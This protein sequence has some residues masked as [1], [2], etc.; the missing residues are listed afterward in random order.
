MMREDGADRSS[1]SNSQDKIATIIM[2]VILSIMGAAIFTSIIVGSLGIRREAERNTCK[3]SDN[4]WRLPKTIIPKSY[5]IE[6][7]PSFDSLNFTGHSDIKLTIEDYTNC[8]FIHR[9]GISL[10]NVTLSYLNDDGTVDEDSS[11]DAHEIEYLDDYELARISFSHYLNKGKTAMLSMDFQGTIRTDLEGFYK[12][13]FDYQGEEHTLAVTHFEAVAARRA[14]PCF[15]EPELKAEFSFS[16]VLNRDDAKNMKHIANM[17]VVEENPVDGDGDQ[18]RVKYQTSV[19]MSTYL[20]A[21]MIGEMEYIEATQD[22]TTFRVWAVKGR[23]VQERGQFALQ[24][25]Q[26][27]TSFYAKFYD[28]PYALPKMDLLAVPDFDAGAMENWGMITFRETALLVDPNAAQSERSYV[29]EV[30]AHEIAH[31][32]SGNLVTMAWWN[33]LWLNEGFA[34]FFEVYSTDSIFPE[35]NLWEK[36]LTDAYRGALTFDASPASHPVVVADELNTPSELNS[37][38]DDISYDKGSMM[39]RMIYDILGQDGFQQWLRKYFSDHKYMAAYT[40]DIMATLAETSDGE[41][42][43][44]ILHSWFHQP[45][46]PVVMLHIDP[47]DSSK[48]TLTQRRFLWIQDDHNKQNTSSTTTNSINSIDTNADESSD[49]SAIKS[50]VW[51]L[52]VSMRHKDGSI[53]RHVFNQ[54]EATISL[55][56]NSDQYLKL[57][58]E[59]MSMYRVAYPESV[60]KQLSA[61]FSQLSTADR[62]GLIDDAFALGMAQRSALGTSNYSIH[63]AMDL[64]AEKLP[65]ER[66]Y[67]VWYAALSHLSRI[68]YDIDQLPIYGMFKHFMGQHILEDPLN[69]VG[70]EYN[71]N[72]DDSNT[73]ALRTLLIDSALRY[74]LES[75]VETA[76]DKYEAF[77]ADPISNPIERDIRGAIYK[78]YVRENGEEGWN[79]MLQR[80][81]NTSAADVPERLRVLHALAHTRVPYLIQE[82]LELAVS[83]H[84]RS[85]DA[86]YFIR[87]IARNVYGRDITWNFIRERYSEMRDRYGDGFASRR[88]AQITTLFSSQTMH[89]EVKGYFLRKQGGKLSKNLNE[90]LTEILINKAFLDDHYDELETW[91]SDMTPVSI[92][93]V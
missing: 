27:V 68:A 16:F 76:L 85:Q 55:N 87:E 80:Y 57:N 51:Y 75:A 70:W 5:S 60:W 37:V 9:Q 52:S 6:I 46:Y 82:T 49:D 61:S 11:K 8:I 40:R 7:E 64:I 18:I 44:D 1:R 62:Y 56:Q 3:S 4:M 89:D 43:D 24:V 78:T 65:D 86:V 29:A 59:Q 83:P 34:S 28:I 17:P 36:Y 72:N 53:E 48:V 73:I 25:A 50:I 81:F 54:S 2:Q 19:P 32:W 74:E 13:V 33:H 41:L 47:Q 69:R 63:A 42:T 66:N 88:L 39:L 10:Q 38:F 91:L 22:G 45:G 77:D 93:K 12:S 79:N 67:A 20:V 26:N 30:I 15:D 71:N 14:F 90:V 23:N 21:F 92:S 84:V 58:A 31:Q 35:W